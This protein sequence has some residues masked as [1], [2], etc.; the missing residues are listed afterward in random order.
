MAEGRAAGAQRL[1]VAVIGLG[2]MG[3]NHARV[4][5]E[6][7]QAELVAVCDCDSARLER[8]ARIDSTT[9]AGYTGYVQMLDEVRPDAVSVAVPTLSH[10][11]AALACIARGVPVLVEKPLAATVDEGTR[12]RD[13]A[14]ARGTPLAVGH[15]ER[16]NPAIAELKRRLDQGELGRLLQMRATRVGP[17]YDRQR[18]VGVVH[19]LATHD[20]DV[21]RYLSGQEVTRA[22]AETQRG[23]RTEH[24]DAVMGVLRFDGGVTGAL[25]VNWLTPEKRRELT[26]VGE[27]GM[28]VAD[29]IAQ[30]LRFFETAAAAEPSAAVVIEI[31]RDEPLRAELSAFLQAARG[32]VPPL[33]GADDAIAAMRVADALVESAARGEAVAVA[34]GRP[35]W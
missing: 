1:R 16:C 18:D 35:A 33:V 26:V 29:Y 7:P 9:V 15:I 23:V 13:A 11:E 4:Y 22:R 21:M 5:G 2:A 12:L 19:D 17:F 27:R 31:E 14:D 10:Y 6:L 28:F 30:E 20:I 24:D 3:S 25:D 32:N 34:G 8:A